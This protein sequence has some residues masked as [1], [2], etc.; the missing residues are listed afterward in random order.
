MIV[1][2]TQGRRRR[3]Q[4]GRY[5]KAIATSR[6]SH[7]KRRSRRRKTKLRRRF[8]SQR[9]ASPYFLSRTFYLVSHVEESVRTATR[10]FATRESGRVSHLCCRFAASCLMRLPVTRDSSQQRRPRWESSSMAPA[11][12]GR[13]SR[14]IEQPR[15]QSWLGF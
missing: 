6:S 3:W 4:K 1:A 9:L 7:R 15:L 12:R 14:S 8:R 5:N 10:R 11:T 13:E 2:A